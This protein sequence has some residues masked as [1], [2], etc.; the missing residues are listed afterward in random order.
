[1]VMVET[2]PHTPRPNTPRPNTPCPNTPRP[3]T[4]HTPQHPPPHTHTPQG[5]KLDLQDAYAWRSFAAFLLWVSAVQAGTLLYCWRCC[6][7]DAGEAAVVNMVGGG[8]VPEG[9]EEGWRG[10]GGEGRRGGL[11]EGRGGTKD[12]GN[13]RLL[14]VRDPEQGA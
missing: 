11:R 7:G 9:V 3:P 1:M 14:R 12:L 13:R 2:T 8:V 10:E 6:G 5:I 4:P